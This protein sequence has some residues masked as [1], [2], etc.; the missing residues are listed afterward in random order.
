MTLGDKTVQS[1]GLDSF[2]KNF[3][4]ISA[5]ADKKIAT[6]VSKNQG[7]AFETTSNIATAAATE[8]PKAA[9]SSLPEVFN[10]YHTGTGLY[11]P[12]FA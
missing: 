2:L 7:R 12:R 3:R 5:E 6:N 9:L 4:R 11:L 1:E 10:F 8:S